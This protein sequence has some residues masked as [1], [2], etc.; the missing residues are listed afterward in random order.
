MLLKVNRSRLPRPERSTWI[1]LLVAITAIIL[2]LFGNIILNP[3]YLGIFIEYLIPTSMIVFFMLYKT[4]IL[5]AILSFIN[6]VTPKKNSIFKPL[7]FKIDVAIRKLNAQKFVFFTNNDNVEI[8]NKVLLYISKNENTRRLK[9][10]AVLNDDDKVYPGLKSDVEV[11]DR[12]YPDIDIEFVEEHGVFGP[13]KIKELSKKWNI[14]VNFMFIGSPG[15]KFPY[16]IQQLGDV[17]LI[18]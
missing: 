17:R 4:R 3:S 16:R 10:V 18:I 2:A 12:A 5:K 11:L 14:P 8:L 1:G 13:D 7:N 6:Y 9:I 15:D